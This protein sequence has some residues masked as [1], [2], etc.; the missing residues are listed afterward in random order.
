VRALWHLA[1]EL[2]RRGGRYSAT[3]CKRPLRISE[4]FEALS[5]SELSAEL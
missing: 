4:S 1:L 5:F 2:G 3:S